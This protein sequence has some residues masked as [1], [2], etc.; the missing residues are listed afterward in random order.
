MKFSWVKNINGMQKFKLIWLGQFVSIMG[1]SMT[2]FALMIWAYQQVG[3]ASTLALMGF[4]SILPYILFSPLA[5]SLVDRYDR[6]KI[7]VFA[8]L[9]A[10]IVT[11]L[12]L[13]LYMSSNLEIWHLY[14]AEA[15]AGAFEAF[16]IPAYISSTTLL[17]PKEKYSQASGMRSFASSSSKVFAPMFAGFLLTLI[18]I[19]GVMIID[20][21]TFFVAMGT[22]I[23]VQIPGLSKKQEDEDSE[24]SIWEDVKFGIVYLVEKRGLF[25]L[26]LV[27]VVI[28]FLAALTYFGILPAMILARSGSNQMALATVQAMLGIGGVVSSIIIS[29]WG[30]PSQ[31]VFT[32]L[33]ATGLSFTLGDL[34]LAVGTT[35]FVWGI[36]AFFAS[37]C[38]PYIMGAENALWQSKVDP[39]VQGR[40]FSTKSM[41]QLVAMP[42]GYITGGLLADYVFEPA[43]ASGWILNKMFGW[44][45]GTGTGAGM[46]VMFIFTGVLGLIICI[47]GFLAKDIR[48]LEINIPDHDLN[49]Q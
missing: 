22:L 28:N 48:D 5:G 10:G 13:F 14:C 11:A 39:G 42:A 32:I 8:D 6:K 23:L 1:T 9:G 18:G 38:I 41:L 33:I 36:A 3:K 29:I 7:M 20:I 44:I 25:L 26:L 24:N 40:V 17:I 46:A 43:M 2:K 31:K 35:P 12:I 19:R 15:L 49:L 30:V 34:L 16:Q 45:V 4:F 27:F 47:I 21:V 37:F